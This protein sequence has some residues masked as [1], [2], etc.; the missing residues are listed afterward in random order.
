MIRRSVAGLLALA[1]LG[2]VSPARAQP[3]PPG[4]LREAVVALFEMPDPAPRARAEALA[5]VL[6]VSWLAHR[7]LTFAPSHSGPSAASPDAFMECLRSSADMNEAMGRMERCRPLHPALAA[8]RA[9]PYRRVAAGA[10]DD[11]VARF[12]ADARLGPRSPAAEVTADPLAAPGRAAFVA[13]VSGEPP[14]L[15]ADAFALQ[16]VLDVGAGPWDA[17]Q[18]AA[19]LLEACDATRA[20]EPHRCARVGAG[21][22]LALHLIGDRAVEVFESPT[23]PRLEPRQRRPDAP[24]GAPVAGVA[25]VVASTPWRLPRSRPQIDVPSGDVGRPLRA[26]VTVPLDADE[27]PPIALLEPWATVDGVE[28]AVH[29]TDPLAFTVPIP[30]PD[31][32]GTHALVVGLR[33]VEGAPGPS[34]GVTFEVGRLGAPVALEGGQHACLPSDRALGWG[35]RLDGGDLRLRGTCVALPWWSLGR[36]VTEVSAHVGGAR[37]RVEVTM[38]PSPVTLALMGLLLAAIALGAWLTSFAPT[39]AAIAH[40]P[41][42]GVTFRASAE[43]A[44]EVAPLTTVETLEVRRLGPFTVGRDP[45]GRLVRLRPGVAVFVGGERRAQLVDAATADAL[46][47]GQRKE[48]PFVSTGS[49]NP[50]ARAGLLLGPPLLAVLPALLYAPLYDAWPALGATALFG[51]AL[52]VALTIS[53]AGARAW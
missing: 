11:N 39:A 36:G 45:E 44:W 19:L 9:P 28:I 12:L 2:A 22:R 27:S 32:P 8:R 13:I 26:R 37:T 21:E 51:L 7:D 20:I 23:G 50:L 47:S 6:A 35:G 49:V 52:I 40:R 10:W 4:E 16:V 46:A 3:A 24:Y 53:R 33:S 29:A 5:R 38:R 17:E 34:A 18:A 41:D 14:P 43:G 31:R 30:P 1:A 42:R 15:E 25:A 48:P